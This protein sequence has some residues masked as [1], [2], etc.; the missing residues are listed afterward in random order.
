MPVVGHLMLFREG[1]GGSTRISFRINADCQDCHLLGITAEALLHRVQLFR[2][3]R[4][5]VGAM[6]VH[7]RHDDWFA[8]ELGER[9]LLTELVRQAKIRS[10][11][12][13]EIGSL[14][15]RW[16]CRC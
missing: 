6:R 16:I 14:Q 15:A 13:L 12:T 1:H 7:E 3:E 5:Y 9:N 11:Y 10:W 8:F 2:Y 4:A